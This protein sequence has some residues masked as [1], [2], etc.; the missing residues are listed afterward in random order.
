MKKHITFLPILVIALLL[1][2]CSKDEDNEPANQIT[3]SNGITISLTW[4]TGGTANQAIE[5]ADLDLGIFDSEGDIMDVSD[6]ESSFE[7]LTMNSQYP[8]G[9]YTVMVL[10]WENFAAKAINYKITAS[11]GGKELKAEGTFSV[12]VEDFTERS[13]MKIVK[14]GSK[15]TVTNL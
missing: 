12:T 3:S 11:G 15:Y 5:D 6:N 1:N 7:N 4:L 10:L 8:D 9:E 2:S 14:K 13:I